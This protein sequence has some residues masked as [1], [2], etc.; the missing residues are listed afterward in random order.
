MTLTFV[1]AN[2]YDARMD[3]LPELIALIESW[4]GCNLVTPAA[5]DDS[6]VECE[7]AA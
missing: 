5:L 2:G 3:R 4:R 1:I 6:D 7:R